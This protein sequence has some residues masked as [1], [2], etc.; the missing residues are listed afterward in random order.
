MTFLR[1]LIGDVSEIYAYMFSLFFSIS[2]AY[3]LALGLR[4][5][6]TRL[7][8]CPSHAEHDLS[9]LGISLGERKISGGK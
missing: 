3:R 2:F 1:G 7:L 6:D 4:L 5:D 8:S 9:V